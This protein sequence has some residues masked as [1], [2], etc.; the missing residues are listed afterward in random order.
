MKKRHLDIE[1][2]Q[3]TRP[4]ALDMSGLS[5]RAF[6]LSSGTVLTASTVVL[7]V[8]LA[9]GEEFA[10]GSADS[11]FTQQ[12]KRILTAVTEHL[13]P[14]G[15]ESPGAIDIQAVPYLEA[16]IFQQGFAEDTRDFILNRV[17][18]L[19][20]VS[21]ERFDLAFFKL[22]F[23]HR[24]SLLR[25]LADRTRWG[26]KWLS[27]LLYYILEALLS[28]PVYGGNPDGIGWKWLEH[29]P[30]FPRPPANK[31]YHRL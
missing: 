12:Q 15:P 7:A 16:T 4:S 27:L 9:L 17:Q 29:Q 19:Q 22:D 13:F 8:P 11:R 18:T 21:M 1:G 6:L 24:E 23:S 5:R 26:R 20:E 14:N 10:Q 2:T 3:T 31:T 28:D 25:Y 30:G